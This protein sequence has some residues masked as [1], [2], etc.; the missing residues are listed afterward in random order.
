MRF[1][2]RLPLFVT[3][4]FTGAA[5]AWAGNDGLGSEDAVAAASPIAKPGQVGELKL[6]D[7]A[8]SLQDR[9]LIGSLEP[10]CELDPGQRVANLQAPLKG[11]AV[12]FHGG[13]RLSSLV[14][15]GGA[16]TAAGI[17]IG[18]SVRAVREHYPNARYDRPGSLEPF[19]QGFVWVNSLRKP[20]MTFVIDASSKRVLTINVPSPNF[21]E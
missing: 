18:S 3:L 1:S 21:C 10:G 9:G 20:K 12:F 16:K 14:I 11:F 17:G 15:E 6:G 13:K 19:P 2:N 5:I 4:A 8:A 7:T